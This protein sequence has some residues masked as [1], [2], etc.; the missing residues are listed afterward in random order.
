MM[1]GRLGRLP[2]APARHAR[3]LSGASGASDAVLRDIERSFGASAVSQ[4]A[5]VIA[6]HSSIE[7]G[8]VGW[9]APQAVVFG[10]STE[11]VSEVVRC[12]AAHRV[13]LVPYGAGTS[14]EGHIDCP[15][16]GT[17]MLDLSQMNEVLAVHEADG[18]A[19]VQAGVTR[20]ALNEH[21][22]H[23]GVFFSVDPGANATIGGMVAT[24]ASGTTTLR[25]GAMR[26]NVMGLRAVMA[27]GSVVD[28]GGRARKSSAGYDLTRLLIGSEGTL[29]IVTEATVRLHAQPEAVAAAVCHFETL[30]AAVDT[31]VGATYTGA[32]PARM[33][34]LDAVTM[35]ALDGYQGQAFEVAPTV[36]FE[37]HGSHAAV[38]E[39]ARA[40]GE[41][42]EGYGG[43]GFRMATAMEDRTALW[44]AR[45]D[46]FWAVKARWP[47]KDVVA[48]DVAVPLTRLAG[49]VEETHAHVR[50]LGITAAPLFGHVGDGNFH[51]LVMYDAADEED[52]GRVRTLEDALIHRALAA[53]GTCTGEHGIGT[54][55]LKYLEHEFGAAAVGVMGAVKAAL[56]PHN[57]LNPGKAIAGTR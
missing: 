32:A 4:N 23:S 57:I 19:R 46:A 31:C 9:S 43:S 33:E 39:Q 53:G 35:A 20:E 52:V 51:L 54:G 17:V 40:V 18:D 25:Y 24:N 13:P 47:G 27:D 21:V 44:K 26:E 45:H 34:L 16:P 55:K 28:T 56:D 12:C 42:A 10:A 7:T 14:V 49:V 38:E 29:G 30:D 1:L 50:E 41:V 6:N 36:F 15:R 2:S 3:A 37:F 8:Y 5:A 48:T 22:R 11:M